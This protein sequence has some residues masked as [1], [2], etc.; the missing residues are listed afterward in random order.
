MNK[1]KF[2]HMLYDAIIEGIE[3]V[4]TADIIDRATIGV[5]VG[6][7]RYFISIEAVDEE[8]APLAATV[9]A[10]VRGR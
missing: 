5:E 10:K 1:K 2:Q 8:Q 3:G 7:K 6:A 9:A 4:T